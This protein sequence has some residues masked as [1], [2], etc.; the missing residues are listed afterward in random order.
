MKRGWVGSHAFRIGGECT[1]CDHL[2]AP[3]TGYGNPCNCVSTLNNG[4]PAQV[5]I[6][7]DANVSKND[8]TTWAGFADDTWRLARRVTLSIGL[9][10]DRYQPSLPA[11]EGPDGQRFT[12]VDPVLTFSNWGPRAGVS[13][14]LT[15]DGKT[16]LKVHYGKYWLYPGPNF[17]S[18]FNPNPSGWSQ[19]YLWTSDANGNAATA[20][21]RGK[22]LRSMLDE[23]G[24]TFVHSSIRDHEYLRASDHRLHRARGGTGSGRADRCSPE[25]Q[26]PAIRDDQRQPAAERLLGSA[27]DRGSGT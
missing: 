24:P 12:A 18:A 25:R 17:T 5:Q 14:D 22:R 2:V 19:T 8:L 10:L 7:L 13:A 9:R 16:V 15:G 1:Q 27:G 3:T 6:L 4:V 23:L 26:T 21:D 20:S 11:Q